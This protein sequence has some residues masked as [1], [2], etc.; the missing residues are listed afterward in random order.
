MMKRLPIGIMV[1]LMMLWFSGN[2]VH[3]KTPNRL[4]IISAA[5]DM[6]DPK[7]PTIEINA[8]NFGDDPQ[9]KLNDELL[10]IE[11]VSD[12]DIT[13]YLD[14]D[15]PP[16]T[17]RLSVARKGFDF[18]HPEKAD[19][20]D[21]T[22]SDVEPVVFKGSPGGLER[23]KIYEMNATHIISQHDAVDPIT[24]KC[25]CGDKSDIALNAGYEIKTSPDYPDNELTILKSNIM[26][27]SDEADFYELVVKNPIVFGGRDGKW[28]QIDTY[29]RCID[30]PNPDN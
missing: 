25:L 20:L 26:Y 6:T 27:Y 21:V 10:T 1:F 30:I 9:V 11:S 3:A 8:L 28:I 18:S 13:A 12:S 16:G 15:I 29:L 2:S 23:S 14:G 7:L 19:S 4:E 17:Y 5:A 24:A 22:I